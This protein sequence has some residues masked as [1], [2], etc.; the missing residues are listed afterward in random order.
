MALKDRIEYPYLGDP[1]KMDRALKEEERVV[2]ANDRLEAALDEKKV[3]IF[4]DCVVDEKVFNAVRDAVI[5]F[6]ALQKKL[7][8]SRCMESETVKR[9]EN[10]TEQGV[11]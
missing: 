8:Y 11:K 7:E 1:K 5:E 3:E 2:G 10:G 9:W 4:G 6:R